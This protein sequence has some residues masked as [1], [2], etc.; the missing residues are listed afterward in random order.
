MLFRSN[1]HPNKQFQNDYNQYG[2]DDFTY[3]V[4]KATTKK[5]CKSEET[6]TIF[7]YQTMGKD[8]YNIEICHDAKSAITILHMSQPKNKKKKIFKNDV[9][10]DVFTGRNVELAKFLGVSEMSIS[11]LVSKKL[12]NVRGYRFVGY[13]T[14]KNQ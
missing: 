12:D 2:I 14:T 6:D 11:Y 13:P 10:G 4:L 5:N 9:T 7:A 3:R 1:R 8:L